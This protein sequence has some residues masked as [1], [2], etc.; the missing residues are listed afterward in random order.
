MP[1]REFL[2]SFD[3]II[4]EGGD[5]TWDTVSEWLLTGGIE[6]LES[7]AFQ[8]KSIFVNAAPN[9]GLSGPLLFGA[10]LNYGTTSPNNVTVQYPPFLNGTFQPTSNSLTGS[11]Y[12]HGVIEEFSPN[13]FPLIVNAGE[14]RFPREEGP[15][16]ETEPVLVGG[17]GCPYSRVF[18][19]AM[20][21]TNFHQ[22]QPEAENVYLNVLESL[23]RRDPCLSVSPIPPPA[24]TPMPSALPRFTVSVVLRYDAFS[25]E[26]SW[27]LTDS[28]GIPVAGV[29]AGPSEKTET[30]ELRLVP[31]DY[32]FVVMDS[33]GDGLCCEQGKGSYRLVAPDGSVFINSDDIDGGEF[34]QKSKQSCFNIGSENGD[35]IPVHQVDVKLLHDGFAEETSWEIVDI[36]QGISVFSVNSTEFQ[37]NAIVKTS[38]YLPPGRYQYNIYD[39]LSDGLCCFFGIGKYS[40]QMDGMELFG[41]GEFEASQSHSFEVYYEESDKMEGNDGN[42]SNE[43]GT[44]DGSDATPPD[45]ENEPDGEGDETGHDHH[46]DED[47]DRGG[48]PDAGENFTAPNA[49]DEEHAEEKNENYDEDHAHEGHN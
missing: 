38:V 44:G 43:G 15:F 26:T 1:S 4:V 20:T 14:G 17:V 45:V 31:G 47:N 41:G 35:I 49:G 10:F 16:D 11:S 23:C 24:P 5:G 32:C 30:T 13:Y 29:Q 7:L 37:N 40:V 12:A 48:R 22:P 42:D 33:F 34:G 39:S 46:S 9:V 6:T 8:E 28:R 27:N 19:G 2:Q 25:H 18:L 21:P 3:I 36:I